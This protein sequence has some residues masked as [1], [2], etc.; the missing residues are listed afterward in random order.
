MTVHNIF[1]KTDVI[2]N[3]HFAIRNRT[4]IKDVFSALHD[5]ALSE[6]VRSLIIESLKINFEESNAFENFLSLFKDVLSKPT[7]NNVKCATAH[8]DIKMDRLSY[9]L[10]SKETSFIKKRI[11]TQFAQRLRKHIEKSLPFKTWDFLTPRD[12]PTIFNLDPKNVLITNVYP[13]DMFKYLVSSLDEKRN[14]NAC[15]GF[16]FFIDSDAESVPLLTAPGSIEKNAEKVQQ[17]CKSIEKEKRC[18]LALF[19]CPGSY[20]LQLERDAKEFTEDDVLPRVMAALYDSITEQHALDT[21]N[22]HWSRRGYRD[23]VEMTF[24]E[25][26]EKEG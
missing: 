7:D 16:A 20:A 25:F 5:Y 3:L 24:I 14:I 13:N 22:D 21:V 26:V 19:G 9:V 8:A 4:D 11:D 12:N 23:Q 1:T 2:K 6:G 10:S 18:P 17:Y 15:N